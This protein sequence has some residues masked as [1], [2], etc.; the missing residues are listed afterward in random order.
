MLYDR[1]TI[2]TID[3][4]SVFMCEAKKYRVANVLFDEPMCATM[5]QGV[6]PFKMMLTSNVYFTG[7]T[8]K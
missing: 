7:K 5:S 6:I 1:T 8:R 4:E 2:V 3:E